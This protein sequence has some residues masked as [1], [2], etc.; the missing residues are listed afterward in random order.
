MGTEAGTRLNS[1][2][3]LRNTY[4]RNMSGGNAGDLMLPEAATDGSAD[5]HGVCKLE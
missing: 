3:F 1:E 5:G 4:G 2:R